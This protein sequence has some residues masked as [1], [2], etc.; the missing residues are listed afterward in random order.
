ME[1]DGKEALDAA[2]VVEEAEQPRKRRREEAT[3]GDTDA[4][5]EADSERS[6]SVDGVSV[7]LKVPETAKDETKETLV[8]SLPISSSRFARFWEMKP[9]LCRLARHF[10]TRKAFTDECSW[11]CVAKTNKNDRKERPRRTTAA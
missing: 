10:F 8:S 1:E 9:L 6:K 5:A 11:A 4:E 3:D 2:D 7:A